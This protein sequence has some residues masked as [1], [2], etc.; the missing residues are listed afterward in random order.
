VSS[1]VV[2][3][4]NGDTIWSAEDRFAGWVDVPLSATGRGQCR[5]ASRQLSA[6]DFSPTTVYASQLSRS[7]ESAQ[8]V[9]SQLECAAALNVRWEL[10]G[11]HYGAWQ[12]WPRRTLRENIGR[13]RFLSRHL[14]WTGRPP[15]GAAHPFGPYAELDAVRHGVHAESLA[16]VAHRV[17][18]F[19]ERDLIRAVSASEDVL[20]VSHGNCIRAMRVI[21]GDLDFD[22]LEESEMAPAGTCAYHAQAEAGSLRMT[23]QPWTYDSGK[24]AATI[25]RAIGVRK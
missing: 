2:L 13:E 11:R 23:P 22:E 5:R 8:I 4:R 12:G 20:V 18:P 16:D 7:I 17:V 21:F 1:T 10:N 25:S 19:I 24:S 9:L 3:L 15:S 14:T 6:R